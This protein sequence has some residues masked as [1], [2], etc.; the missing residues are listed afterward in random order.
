MNRRKHVVAGVLIGLLL[1]LVAPGQ[2]EG[3]RRSR[4][5]DSDRYGIPT[6]DLHPTMPRDVFTFARVRYSSFGRG[7]RWGGGWAT[8]YR[9]ADLNFSYRLN[10][11]TALK[12]D[13]EGLVV[14]L[15][16][17]HLFDFPFIYMVEPGALAF[18]EVE[19]ERLREYLLS[20]GFLM[21]DDFW[22]DREWENFEEEILRVFP[23]Q[24]ITDISPEHEIFNLVFKLPPAPQI[25]NVR[26]GWESQFTGV[27]WEEDKAPGAR[28][29]HY[30]GIF[31]ENGRLMVMICH[32]TDL[33]DGWERE[34]DNEYYFREF[35]E[36]IAYPL[37]I[38]ILFYA[39]TH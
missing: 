13:P 8:D 35:S 36:K 20:G 1:A 4:S 15:T 37:G 33:G 26:Q 29:P 24:A 19:V 34:G 2:P 17:P 10:E 18:D 21:V 11:M 25:P 39:M 16:D 28:T 3:R 23:G 31:D 7:W 12:V 14:E 27:T 9:D 38:N 6:W 22:G 30:R 32:N 5:Y